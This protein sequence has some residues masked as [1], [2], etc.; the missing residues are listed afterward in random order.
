MMS[1][2]LDPIS[3]KPAATAWPYGQTVD[4][5]PILNEQQMRWWD[6]NK[7]YFPPSFPPPRRLRTVDP[8]K[9]EDFLRIRHNQR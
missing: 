5:A 6:E 9:P 3:G 8:D 2:P 4:L 7:K 1:E